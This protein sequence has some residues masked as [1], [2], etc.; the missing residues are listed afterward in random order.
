VS[1]RRVP[2]LAL[3]GLACWPGRPAGTQNADAKPSPSPPTTASSSTLGAA[4]ALQKLDAGRRFLFGGDF[5]AAKSTFEVASRHPKARAAALVG[6]AEAEFQL[7]R[8]AAAEA[9][10]AK[11]V[12][13]G[14]GVRAHV[15]LGNIRF[16]LR[17]YG[18][19]AGGYEAALA[20][21][22]GNPEAGRNLAIAKRTA[23]AMRR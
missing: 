6:L 19:A 10:A 3:L 17:D 1:G 5:A 13:A 18:G 8:F 7:G 21:D 12:S 20:L 11:A 23:N 16:K 14:G 9:L 15:V 22:R 4:A 2:L